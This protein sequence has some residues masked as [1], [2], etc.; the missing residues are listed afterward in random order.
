MP[1]S[2]SDLLTSRFV[3][4]TLNWEERSRTRTRKFY[5]TNKEREREGGE[6]G[7]G[8]SEMDKTKPTIHLEV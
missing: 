1:N 2:T 6:G 3:D 4:Q 8:V 5:F 7:G